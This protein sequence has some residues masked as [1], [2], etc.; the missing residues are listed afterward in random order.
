[1]LIEALCLIA[2]Q[3]INYSLNTRYGRKRADKYGVYRDKNGDTRLTKNCKKVIETYNNNGE[4]VLKYINNGEIVKNINDAEAKERM[5]KA[6]KD[7]K[8]YYLYLVDKRK[9]YSKSSYNIIGDRY[10]HINDSSSKCYVKRLV[11]YSWTKPNPPYNCWNYSGYYYMDMNFNF[12]EPTDEQKEKDI[13]LFGDNY[14]D[15]EEYILSL[16]KAK[17]KNTKSF[18][19][20][21]KYYLPISERPVNI[22]DASNYAIV[23]EALLRRK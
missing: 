12:C 14:Q 18:K 19:D 23:N 15:F 3:K 22:V 2:L 20:V 10:K 8:T 11:I 17:I 4:K 1:M 5:E 16:L 9:G 6:I 21:S 13:E 7:G